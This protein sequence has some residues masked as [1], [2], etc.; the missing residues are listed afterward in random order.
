MTV[1]FGV[2]L[3]STMADIQSQLQDLAENGDMNDDGTLRTMQQLLDH[4]SNI[5]SILTGTEQF[6]YNC[7]KNCIN[8]WPKNG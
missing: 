8:A 2:N 7:C 4:E 1:N 3:N 5:N 6:N